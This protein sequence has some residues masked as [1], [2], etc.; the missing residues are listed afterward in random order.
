[1]TIDHLDE[2]R[3]CCAAP[4]YDLRDSYGGRDVLTETCVCTNC[5]ARVRVEWTRSAVVELDD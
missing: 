4:D 3:D 1:M 2:T 5:R